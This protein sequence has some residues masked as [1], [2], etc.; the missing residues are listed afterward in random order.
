MDVFNKWGEE[1]GVT[2]SG[3]PA[4]GTTEM[5]SLVKQNP[6]AYDVV[7][8][9]DTGMA[10]A[11]KEDVLEPIDLSKVP[12]FKENI[13]ESA[14]GLPFLTSD[15]GKTMG[16]IRE[17]GAT[18]YAYN[19]EKIDT[20]L[21]TWDDLK[22]PKYEEKVSLID[23]TID[24]LSNCAISVNLNVNK[25]PGNQSKTD[26]MF[27]EAKAQ[28][29][30][31]FSYWSNGATSIRYLRQENAWICEA[32]GGRVLA[33]QEEGYDHIKYVIP[34]EGAMAWADNLAIVKGTKHKDAVHDLLNFTYQREH[35]LSIAK[36][37][38][39]TVQVP[40]PPKWMKEFPDYAPASDLA[41]R[42]WSVLLPK[43]EAWSQ[44]LGQIKA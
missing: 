21:T 12:N 15:D 42:D 22:D 41:F 5:L 25:V 11:Q 18:G 27:Q 1:N 36:G 17:N 31:V 7:A 3:T 37:M 29:T 2:V 16:L 10:R 35:L 24:R 23:R 19:T 8:L 13:R 28:D 9:N 20:E 40:N 43:Q 38:N 34:E 14:R 33:L 26:K 39:Y 4:G 32:W 30:N 6:G 44:R